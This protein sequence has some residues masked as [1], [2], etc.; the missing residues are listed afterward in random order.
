M[1]TAHLLTISRSILRGGGGGCAHPTGYWRPLVSNGCWKPTLPCEQTNMSNKNAFQWDPYYLLQWPPGGGISVTETHTPSPSPLWIGRCLWKH[2][3]PATSLAGGKI[4]WTNCFG[5]FNF[6][7]QCGAAKFSVSS[8]SLQYAEQTGLDSATSIYNGRIGSAD[9]FFCQTPW[10][11]L[12]PQ[13]T[14]SKLMYPCFKHYVNLILKYFPKQVA[15]QMMKWVKCWLI[16]SVIW[17]MCF[18]NI[19]EWCT[20]F[21]SSETPIHILFLTTCQ[22]IL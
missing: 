18:V 14:I 3:L 6:D 5:F 4:C 13:H 16:G 12:P 21:L 20:G 2:Y 19:R 10:V 8:H 9:G 15:Y 11:Y 17:H 22:R 7:L 1:R